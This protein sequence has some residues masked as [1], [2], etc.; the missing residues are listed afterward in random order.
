MRATET[1]ARPTGLEPVTAGLEGRCSIQ[2]GSGALP[3]P[4]VAPD[5]RTENRAAPQWV[6]GMEPLRLPTSCPSA[7]NEVYHTR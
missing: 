2:M 3:D 7:A 5:G 4:N 6:A 1:L